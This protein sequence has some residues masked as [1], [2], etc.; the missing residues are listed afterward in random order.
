M[1]P[2]DTW[3]DWAFKSLVGLLFI[4]G[5]YLGQGVKSDVR[6]LQKNQ[7]QAD[8]ALAAYK[9]EVE[10]TFAKDTSVQTSLARIHDRMDEIGDDIKKLIGAVGATSHH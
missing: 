10:R 9:L 4:I 3:L 8:L 6:E 1:T 5:G 7:A 2:D